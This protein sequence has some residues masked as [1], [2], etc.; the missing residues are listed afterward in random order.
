VVRSDGS[1][2]QY[3]GGAAAK[4]ALLDLEDAWAS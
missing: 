3:V 1:I 4:S 2:G